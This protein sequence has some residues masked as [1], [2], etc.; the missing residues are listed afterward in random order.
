[1]D[2]STARRLPEDYLPSDEELIEQV[3]AHPGVCLRELCTK[4]WP[5]L[6]WA[7]LTPGG[8]SAIQDLRVFP[9]GKRTVRMTTAQYLRDRM[10]TLLDRGLVQVAPFR[11][12]EPGDAGFS[13]AV[14]ADP[15]TKEP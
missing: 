12:N 15:R 11:Y 14:P 8:D 10:R 3:C 2:T 5:T 9:E 4:L 6:P 13:Y 1:M 7:P